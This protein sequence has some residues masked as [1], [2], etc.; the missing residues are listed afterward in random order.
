MDA[1][2][3]SLAESFGFRNFFEKAK[4][5]IPHHRI[6]K[7][8]II[9][10]SNDLKRINTTELKKLTMHHAVSIIGQPQSFPF[11]PSLLTL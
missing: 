7:Q 6:I 3:F 2:P 11:L 8:K 10:M 5:T 4:I 1:R 9:E